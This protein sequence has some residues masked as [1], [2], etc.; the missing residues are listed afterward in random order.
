[1]QFSSTEGGVVQKSKTP[2]GV[3]FL[4]ALSCFLLIPTVYYLK[5]NE[6]K[7]FQSGCFKS[8]NTPPLPRYPTCLHSEKFP[9][10][11]W[12]ASL[13]PWFCLLP[14]KRDLRPPLKMG[15]KLCLL[16]GIR[17]LPPLRHRCNNP[18]PSYTCCFPMGK[19]P[20]WRTASAI[21][22]LYKVCEIQVYII[23]HN[24]H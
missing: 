6:N 24:S 1:V 20:G 17:Y 19:A 18:Y 3:L 22:R 12:R 16:I 9:I 21:L 14:K 23:E 11:I 8:G 5:R 2:V 4:N 7:E 13:D 15:G 10:C